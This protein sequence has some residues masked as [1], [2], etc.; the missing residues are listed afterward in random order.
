MAIYLVE[1]AIQNKRQWKL[2]RRFTNDLEAYDFYNR[3]LGMWSWNGQTSARNKLGDIIIY[4]IVH[5]MS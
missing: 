3:M 2:K 4:R 1:H 5:L